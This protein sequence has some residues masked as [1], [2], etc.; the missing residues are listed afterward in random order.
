MAVVSPQQ[1]ARPG[2][3]TPTLQADP[4][5]PVRRLLGE[6]IDELGGPELTR[7]LGR[8]A[9]AAQQRRG[10]GAQLRADGAELDAIVARLPNDRAAAVI[11]ACAMTLAVGRL[12]REANARSTDAAG[13]RPGRHD[14]ELPPLAIRLVLTAHPTDIARRSMLSKRRTVIECLQALDDP[15]R[16]AWA[17]AEVE[18]QL[19]EALSLWYATDEVRS[20][21]PR[22]QD[23]VRR[24]LCFFE[25][26]LYDAAAELACARFTDARGPVP[27]RFGSWAGAD[28]DGNPDVTPATILDTAQAHR[29]AALTLL[30]ERVESLR[31]QFSQAEG[32]L[33]L[34]D[35]LR[36]SL[37]KDERELPRTAAELASRYPHEAREPLRRKLAFVL[38]RLRVTLAVAHGDGAGPGSYA[39]GDEL[40][41]DLEQI[42]ASAGARA[43]MTGAIQRVIWQARVFGFHLAT[44]EARDNAPE[45]QRACAV[46]LPGYGA[47]RS[48]TER[49]ALLTRACLQAD[50]P[51][52]AAG[53][54][55]RPALAMDAI[56]QAIGIHGPAAIDTFIVS[57]CERPSDLLCAL[58]LARRSGLF[59]PPQGPPPHTGG[60]SALELVPLFERGAAL[61]RATETLGILYGNRAYAAHLAARDRTQEVMLGYSDAGKEMGFL[62][63][64]WSLYRAQELLVGQAQA[65]GVALRLF[66]GRGGSSPRGGGPTGRLIRAQPPG[67]V[68]GQIKLTEQGEVISAKFSDRRLA[69][70]AL[71]DT[72]VAVAAATRSPG[73]EPA[74]GWRDELARAAAVAGESYARLVS[75]TQLGEVLS[76]AT[77]LGVLGELNIGSRPVSRGGGLLAG[78]RAI[79]W[80]FSWAQTRIALPAWYG[81]GRGLAGGDLALQRAM[82]AGWPLFEHLIE[83]LAT[84]LHETD[85]QIG[86]HYFDLAHDVCGAARIWSLIVAEHE[87]TVD[88]VGAVRSLPVTTGGPADARPWLDVL[89]ALQ[90]AL[91]RRDREGD[92]GA[93]EPLLASIAAIATGLGSTG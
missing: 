28:M 27:L 4:Q 80:V 24:L 57:N 70:A 44:L 18:A 20:L 86:A 76:R 54:A 81:A 23:E 30:I 67:S 91:L 59:S 75:D 25:S 45:L 10:D 34:T 29:I 56:A 36:R 64:Q 84:A 55:P 82:Y 33:R 38:A 53:P 3:T 88:R 12:A 48:E 21:R 60:A 46:L 50:L 85:T 31:A 90:V 51:P 5:E 35:E 73:R 71:S 14:P 16:D 6:V 15:R 77:P 49:A 93:R 7:L 40:C 79:P 69:V 9:R 68:A 52:R 72:V 58:W 63:G 11:R 19:R 78:L 66:H 92:G 26:S 39:S 89:A 37:A 17:R 1:R 62:A 47:A 41:D 13:L 32:S 8:L 74:P 22:V 87:L 83:T 43:V 61:E 42:R 2:R 65:R